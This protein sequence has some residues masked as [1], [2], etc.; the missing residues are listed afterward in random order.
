MRGKR[1]ISLLLIVAMLC[2]FVPTVATPAEAAKPT[3]PDLQ[4]T[5]GAISTTA[6]EVDALFSARSENQHPRIL[7]DADKFAEIRQLIQEDDYMKVLYAR[8]YEEVNYS[9]STTA[10]WMD[11]PVTEYSIP[12]GLR[13]LAASRQA[14]QRIIWMSMLYQLTGERR[15]AERAVEEMLA[16][17]DETKFPDWNHNKHYL[18]VAQMAYGVGIGYD[19]LYH[20][21]TEDQ[22]QSVREALYRNVILTETQCPHGN[23]YNWNQ[24]CMAGFA[25]AATAI[26]EYYPEECSALLAKTVTT[27]QRAL[28]LFTPLGAYPEAASYYCVGAEYGAIYFDTL[29]STL[30]TDFGLTDLPGMRESGNYLLAVNGYVTNFNFGDCDETL[31]SGA[32]L[33]WYATRYN[34]PELS[35]WQRK[36]QRYSSGELFDEPLALLWY[37][38]ALV[39]DY[40]E[41]SQQLDYLMYSDSYQSVASF[42]SFSADPYQVYAAI[43]SGYNSTSHSDMDIGTFVMEAMGERW[44]TELGK[45]NYNLTGYGTYS[46]GKYTEDQGRWKVYRKRA[47]GQNTLVINPSTAGGQDVEGAA[48]ITDYVSSYDGGYATVDMLDAYDNYGAT[49]ANRALMLFDNRSRVLL[50]DEVTMESASDLY[51][52]AHTQA[53]ISISADGKTAEL[54]MNG[55]TMLAQ[56]VEPAN[57]V[58]TQMTADPLVELPSVETDTQKEKDRSAFRKLAIH[59]SNV[60]SANISVVFTPILEEADRSK[61]LPSVTLDTL[62]SLLHDYDETTALTKNADGVYEIYNV[63]QLCLLS[64]Q[65][66]AGNRYENATFVLMNDIDMQGRTF[67][68]I[69]GRSDRIEDD[70]EQTYGVPFHGTFEGN[71][72]VIRNLCIFEPDRED[73]GFFGALYAATIRNLGI[74]SGIVFGAERTAAVAGNTVK[75]TIENCYNKAN[76]ISMDK[77]AGGLVGQFGTGSVIKNSYNNADIKSY[78][79]GVGGLVGYVSSK[80]E[81]TIENSYHVGNLTDISGRTGMIGHYL[82]PDGHDFEVGHVTVTNSYSTTRLKGTGIVDDTTNETY[83]TLSKQITQA[84]LVSKAVDLGSAFI[85]D[86]EW[87]NDG[88]PVLSWQCDTVLPSDLALSTAAELRLLSHNVRSGNNYSGKMVTLLNDVDL[89]SREW[90]PI[91]GVGGENPKFRGTFDGRGYAVKNL[92]VSTDY[93][94]TG[95]FGS[96]SGTIRNFGI[97][98]GDVRGEQHVGGITGGMTGTMENCYNRATVTGNRRVAGL[99]GL[100]YNTNFT[101]CYNTGTITATTKEAGG[102]VAYFNS[103]TD[104]ATITN[105]YNAGTISGN[106]KGGIAGYNDGTTIAITNCYTINAVE[107]VNSTDKFTT[108]NCSQLSETELKAL[109]LTGYSFDSLIPRNGGYPVLNTSLYGSAAV[110]AGEALKY[111]NIT[112]YNVN[113]ADDLR[114]LAYVVNVR[115]K[116][117]PNKTVKLNAD[118]DLKNQEWIPIGGNV[119]DESATSRPGFGGTFEG[120]GHIIKNMS[121]TSGNLYVGLFGFTSGA[122]IKNVGVEN[123]MVIGKEKAAG[124]IGAMRTGSKITDC[125]N[126]ANVSGENHVGGI[127]G[128]FSGD[129]NSVRNCY[130]TG[131]VNAKSATA[132]GIVGY[133]AGDATASTVQNCYNFSISRA[134]IIGDVNSK[135]TDALMDNCY[136]IDTV[137]LVSTPRSL[138]VTN[139]EKLTTANLAALDTTLGSSFTKDYQVQNGL[140]PVLTWQN[141]DCPTSLTTDANGA[142]LINSADEL[143]LFSYI[144]NTYTDTNG[145]GFKGKK[146]ILTADVDLERKPW[147]PIGGYSPSGGRNFRGTFDGGGHKISNIYCMKVGSAADAYKYVGLFGAVSTG[148]VENV[149]IESGC[150]I[151]LNYVAGII[152]NMS[153]GADM[154]KCYN[155]ATVYGRAQVGG[156][157]GMIN[158]NNVVVENCY[159]RG[160]V[161]SRT[162]YTGA[163][164]LVGYLASNTQGVKITNCYD[165]GNYIT[166]ICEVNAT[167]SGNVVKNVYSVGGVK[168]VSKGTGAYS[169]DTTSVLTPSNMR[170]Y[171]PIL[172]LAFAH[173]T[174]NINDGYPILMWEAEYEE[175]RHTELFFDYT[176]SE[177]DQ[178]RYDTKTY[179]YVQFDDPNTINWSTP[180]DTMSSVE[181]TDDVLTLHAKGTLADSTHPAVYTDTIAA[182]SNDYYPL[183]F[184]TSEA[185]VFQ[186][187]FKMKNLRVGD[188]NGETVNP[189]LKLVYRTRGV[190]GSNGSEYVNATGNFNDLAAYLDADEWLVVTLKLNSNKNLYQDNI[191]ESLRIYFGGVESISED[192][193][194]QIDIDYIYIGSEEHAP[195]KKDLYFTYNNTE[196][197]QIRYDTKTYGYVQYDD[198]NGKNWNYNS[199]LLTGVSYGDGALTLNVRGEYDAAVDYPGVYADTYDYANSN[200]NPLYYDPADA[201]VYQIRFKMEGMTQTHPDPNKTGTPYV[202]L[203]LMGVDVN[204]EYMNN[205]T[206]LNQPNQAFPTSVLTSGE[207]YIVTVELDRTKFETCKFITRVRP[208]FGQ[209]KSADANNGGT[210][211]ID[212]V[213]LGT[214]ENMPVKQ[215]T[216]TFTDA[217]GNTLQTVKVHEGETAVFTKTN[218]TKAYTSDKHYT[219]T[220]WDKTL[221][222]VTSDMTVNPVF[223]EDNHTFKYTSTNDSKHKVTCTCG[224]SADEAHDYTYSETK[225]PTKSAAGSIQGVCSD[226]NHKITIVLPKLSSTD[227]TVTV[228]KEATC[229]DKGSEK[230]VWKTTTYGTY[231]YT[232]STN[233]LGHNYGTVVTQP[234]CEN[235]GYTTYTCKRCDYSY[236]A[237]EVAALGH[238][239]V[240]DQAVAA[241]CTATGLTEGKHCSR[242]NKVLVAQTTTAALGHK[243]V[244]DA[245]VAATCTQTGLTE[246]KHCSR[247]NTVLVAQT[248]V[249]KLGHIEVID[250]AVAPTCTETG[251]TQGKHCSRCNEVLV[252]QTVVAKLGHK[253]VIDAAVAPTCTESGLTEGKHCSRCNEVLVAQKT[254]AALGHEWD[255]GKVTKDPT[256]TQKGVLTFTCGNDKTHTDTKEIEMLLHTD[257]NSDELC[258]GCEA[259][260]SAQVQNILLDY[261]L[262]VDKDV[263]ESVSFDEISTEEMSSIELLGVVNADG[264][265]ADFGTATMVDTDK[266]GIS[267]TLRFVP[268]SIIT[269]TVR[270]R[271]K[272]KFTFKDGNTYYRVIPVV[273]I[274]ATV[275]YYETDFSDSFVETTAKRE[276]GIAV[277]LTEDGVTATN[278]KRMSNVE[279]DKAEGILSGEIT[280][281]DPYVTVSLGK[282]YVIQEG[283]VVRVRMRVAANSIHDASAMQA[284]LFFSTPDDSEYY[285]EKSTNFTHVFSANG[286]YQ[287]LTMTLQPDCVGMTVDKVRFDPVNIKV[288]GT[289]DPVRFELDWIYIGPQTEDVATHVFEDF[290]FDGIEFADPDEMYKVIKSMDAEL[291]TDAGVVKGSITGSDPFFVVTNPSGYNYKIQEGDVVKVRIKVDTSADL[292]TELLSAQAFIGAVENGGN[293]TETVSTEET[294]FIACGNY[295]VITMPLCETAIGY[296]VKNIRIDPIDTA[297]SDKDVPF[298]IDWVYIGPDIPVN[299]NGV[300]YPETQNEWTK[301]RLGETAEKTATPSDDTEPY[302]YDEAYADDA[303]YSAGSSL[304]VVG[305][306]VPQMVKD[307]EGNMSINYDSVKQYTEASFEF[308]GTG[309]DIISRTDVNQGAL[310]VIVCDKDGNIV[311]SST[312]VNSGMSVMYQVPVISVRV[313][314]HGE[315]VAHVF[316]NAPFKHEISA[317][318]RGGEFYFDAVRIYGTI[319]SGLGGAD[320]EYAYTVY[321]EHGEADPEF[322]ELR[323]ILV[324][325]PSFNVG[326]SNYIDGVVYLDAP[327]DSDEVTVADYTAVGPNNEVY[328]GKNNAI[329]FKLVVEGKT[330][331]RVDIGA[332][333]VDGTVVNLCTTVQTNAPTY[334]TGDEV[335][336]RSSTAQYF[337]LNISSWQK[338]ADGNNYVYVTIKNTGGGVLSIT[339]LKFGYG[340]A[341]KSQSI[342]FKIDRDMID[343]LANGTENQEPMPDEKLS[344]TMSI[345]V[346]AEMQVY[347]T[348]PNAIV[349]DYESFYL[350]VVKDV[351]GGESV[352]CTYSLDQSNLAESLNPQTGVLMGYNAVFTGIFASEMG[353]NFTAT[354]YAVKEDGTVYYGNAITSS[355]KTYLME[356][357]ADSATIAELKTLAVDMLNYGAAAQVNF[358]Y[359][360]EHLVNADL[361]E[362]QKA[363]GTQDIPTATDISTTVGDGAKITTS[364]S[365]QNKV[366]LYVN[367]AYAKSETSNLEFVVK[368]A[369]GDVLE[370]FAP[371]VAAAKLCQGVYG[372]VGARQMREPIVIELYDNGVLVSQT[373]TWNIESYVAQTRANSASSEALIATVNAMLAYGDSAAIYLTASGQ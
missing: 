274:P 311:T 275:A 197:D 264:S 157:I 207:Y 68:P 265:D 20:F 318:N 62:E 215:Y 81:V 178:T 345:S 95:F 221:T 279:L 370:R 42:R 199:Q 132:A 335:E 59:L 148:G 50:R 363:L 54:T 82:T 257:E 104:N 49:S 174:E 53:D 87:E 315:Y 117:F 113:N 297:L 69:G 147:M 164:G 323:S 202:D 172:G 283:D 139:S 248:V 216:V 277:E 253:E 302:G 22:R 153:G 258:D 184:D 177:A 57:A 269:K 61:A 91:G 263:M 142:Y 321:Q 287:V 340:A 209:V 330:P 362:E 308:T 322:R 78:G 343:S 34:M 360:V 77:H 8:I 1:I 254:V 246:G 364:V 271:C 31:A 320:N 259:L 180:N 121:V 33:H 369:N 361:T 123:G 227:Y 83:D 280:G 106:N 150:L 336:I 39:E 41:D 309:F 304:F 326:E 32:M 144:V 332:K 160:A 134:G 249:A 72:H 100:S 47:E 7:A 352:S 90:V 316:V 353:D 129:G 171:Y 64:D 2:S 237:D 337:P 75:T 17:C 255:S 130:N 268:D 44:F 170:R 366:M 368:N 300:L 190:T 307:S 65:V 67:K 38:P 238:A 159:N 149:G 145:D 146:V 208:Y 229:T 136:T 356:K 43:K 290:D 84:E 252:A 37:D 115:K 210:I 179:S 116:A 126:R 46:N 189:Y 372:N 48:Q 109:T 301:V 220:G 200:P 310:R 371:T 45:D 334:A 103:K 211:T 251:L 288:T 192:Q 306:G 107:L 314:E 21:M 89:E 138:T 272:L 244:K 196:E 228:T 319:D 293:P 99:V 247:C 27:I 25:V 235:G 358:G 128:M 127:V 241:T 294:S 270:L 155:K 5:S 11:Q 60:T 266:D 169:L 118:I 218:P 14:S 88:Y 55:K 71:G 325:A 313:E 339:N 324:D 188:K 15:F 219:F 328:L 135:L 176:N 276:S 105:C 97:K 198:P 284:K 165:T 111:D 19:W 125:Y 12:D 224:Y 28:D 212:Y 373:L 93:I 16:V 226:C 242:C 213:Y 338:D 101:N 110:T 298:E 261:A 85:A 195:G 250:A 86:C 140:Y 152:G 281:Q 151:G 344:V 163:A 161:Y 289:Y 114:T 327:T 351:A 66:R 296:T 239:E 173:D 10:S 214:R 243:E 70:G 256:C 232:V 240:V 168:M 333:S 223:K 124:L 102:I 312:V 40:D 137:E 206:G 167:G 292:N 291:D 355:I 262:T 285:S 141:A 204:G 331:A 267:E 120:N 58:F 347:Y 367:C 222:N 3:A 166:A 236:K 245:A 273:V 74:E 303:T 365:L 186:I 191:V 194:G 305:T 92:R 119:S 23:T 233:A 158:T 193:P 52:F 278:P 162:T 329:A 295:R 181:M 231:T 205:E 217:S 29:M 94:C 36:F 317:L 185:E 143:R 35:V 175:P 187:R 230:Y 154:R 182:Y 96:V 63:E 346:G 122:T 18:D 6:D 201:E 26:Y 79:E 30:G 80:S 348:I 9:T 260:V 350:E 183:K 4:S 342:N 133:M 108:T 282:Q 13:L 225:A 24:W 359:D 354:L 341:G 299:D 286:M 56:I 76:V 51:W 203:H 349:K 98:S 131:T 156:L 357:L 234:D 112:E 73:V